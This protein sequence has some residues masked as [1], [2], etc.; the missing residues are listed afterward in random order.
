MDVLSGGEKQRMAV[1]STLLLNS[2]SVLFWPVLPPVPFRQP[3]VNPH[4]QIRGSQR[5]RRQ[6]VTKLLLMLF[7]FSYMYNRW[8]DFSTTSH[9]LPFLMNAQ[10]LLVWTSK[11]LCILGVGR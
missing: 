9:S 5:E 2:L 8:L 7:F 1:S 11:A 10:V 3:E 6:T 4:F